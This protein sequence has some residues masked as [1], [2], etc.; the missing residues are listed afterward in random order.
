MTRCLLYTSVFTRQHESYKPDLIVLD[1]MLP[2]KDGYDAVSYTHLDVYKRQPLVGGFAAESF[3]L[4]PV[5]LA[6]SLFRALGLYVFYRSVEDA[7]QRPMGLK[8]LLPRGRQKQRR[9]PGV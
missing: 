2:G 7:A 9:L 1:L 6:S 3:G 5:F 8:D 4:R